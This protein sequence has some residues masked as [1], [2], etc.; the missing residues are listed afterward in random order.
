MEV[1][2]INWV[3]P[4]PRMHRVDQ[5]SLGRKARYHHPLLG[6]LTAHVNDERPRSPCI[7]MGKI[8][9]PGQQEGTGLILDGYAAGPLRSQVTC[10]RRILDSLRDINYYLRRQ[11]VRHPD[12]YP[13]MDIENWNGELILIANQDADT[14]TFGLTFE[15]GTAP[16]LRALSVQWAGGEL[17]D[18]KAY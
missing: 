13:S 5:W 6:E 4:H 15:W 14:A 2:P 17:F 7:W 11:M 8:R 9:R 3:H 16:R 1:N 18:P 10:V 12:R